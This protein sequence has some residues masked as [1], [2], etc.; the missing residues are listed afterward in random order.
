MQMMRDERKKKK[1]WMRLTKRYMHAHMKHIRNKKEKKKK[2]KK[3]GYVYVSN[4]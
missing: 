4:T 2:K 1:V 3:K